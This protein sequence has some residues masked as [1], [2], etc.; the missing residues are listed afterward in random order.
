MAE[1]EFPPFLIEI[2]DVIK[3]L[4][5]GG[6]CFLL[7]GY[8]DVNV[9]TKAGYFFTGSFTLLLGSLVGMYLNPTGIPTSSFKRVNEVLS[10]LLKVVLIAL[11]LGILTKH[12]TFQIETKV[13][14]Y[15][16]KKTVSNFL[17]Y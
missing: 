14:G 17:N 2:F 8:L 11:V 7:Y 10:I 15:P 5:L 1:K 4:I 9:N 16:P 6:A 3:L 12:V 13:K